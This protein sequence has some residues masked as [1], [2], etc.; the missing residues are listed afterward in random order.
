MEKWLNIKAR[1]ELWRKEGLSPFTVGS[2][3][4]SSALP[5]SSCLTTGQLLNISG[6]SVPVLKVLVNTIYGGFQPDLLFSDS[7]SWK[8]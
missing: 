5:P 4:E 3:A 6:V 1:K 2:C 8:S 7:V